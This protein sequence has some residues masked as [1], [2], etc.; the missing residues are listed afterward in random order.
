M[1][2]MYASASRKIWTATRPRRHRYGA[3]S[4][5]P[6]PQRSLGHL[7]ICEET[8]LRSCLHVN[9]LRVFRGAEASRLGQGG[10]QQ[11][12]TSAVQAEKYVGLRRSVEDGN[13][14]SS[15]VF[16]PVRS[17][18][19]ALACLSFLPLLQEVRLFCKTH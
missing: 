10:R 19:P 8:L 3:I 2:R 4:L 5:P 17:F 15:S 6:A 16:W 9:W 1:L 7:N 18:C 13:A 11:R 14:R 12:Q